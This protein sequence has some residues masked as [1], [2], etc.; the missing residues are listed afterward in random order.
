ME[1][2]IKKNTWVLVDKPIDAKV[3]NY[4]WIYKRMKG[5]SRKELSRFMTRLVAKGLTQRKGVD[6]CDIFSLVV[7][8][9]IILGVQ[10]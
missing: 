6:F 1:S 8:I 2:L 5:I 4:K 9:F 10:K 3:V 7:K